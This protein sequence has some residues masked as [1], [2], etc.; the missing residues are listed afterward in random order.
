MIVTGLHL[1]LNAIDREQELLINEI[2]VMS[3]AHQANI[4]NFVDSYLVGETLWVRRRSGR[5]N[6]VIVV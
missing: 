5:L 4:V 6:K 2:R 1:N 3:K